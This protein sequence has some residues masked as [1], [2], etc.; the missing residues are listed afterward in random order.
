MVLG[1]G[2][3]WKESKN[4]DIDDPSS[5][6]KICVQVIKAMAA[7]L[8]LQR[9]AV[10][11]KTS[12]K[13]NGGQRSSEIISDHLRSSAQR[14]APG[15]H[16]YL[17]LRR[18]WGDEWRGNKYTNYIY[19]GILTNKY[20][21]DVYLYTMQLLFRFLDVSWIF[22]VCLP[23]RACDPERYAKQN[24]TSSQRIDSCWTPELFTGSSDT[25]PKTRWSIT[26]STDMFAHVELVLPKSPNEPVEVKLCRPYCLVFR[27]K[28]I[29]TS[30]YTRQSKYFNEYK[31][32]YI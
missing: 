5:H 30:V 1:H 25:S 16:C 14:T 18:Q 31:F 24:A 9:A 21:I 13:S 23:S 7:L 32:M 11:Q 4:I 22:L 29:R 8:F 2:K 10:M 3:L 6:A 17:M 15:W 20:N 26:T 12:W 27:C 28:D 19:I